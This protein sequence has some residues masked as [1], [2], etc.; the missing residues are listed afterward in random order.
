MKFI[1]ELTEAELHF[2]V[3]FGAFGKLVNDLHELNQ[4][5]QKSAAALAQK[6]GVTR[7]SLQRAASQ[8]AATQELAAIVHSAVAAFGGQRIA[9]VP[10]EKL[11]ELAAKFTEL[12]IQI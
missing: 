4:D 2:A 3:G 8:F 6:N 7:E 12:G 11:P 10:D 5:L 9:D 1:I